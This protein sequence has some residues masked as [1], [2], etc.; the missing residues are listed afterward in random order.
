MEYY[1]QC[2]DNIFCFGIVNIGSVENMSSHA[3]KLHPLLRWFAAL[4][5]I[6]WISAQGLCQTHCLSS[7][8]NDDSGEANCH[9]NNSS[10]SHH[11]DERA[12]KPNNEDRS[13][14]AS[15]MT[16]KAALSSSAT[17]PFIT[18]QFSLLYTLAP[19]TLSL[20]AT[21]IEPVA[22][23]SRQ[24]RLR[25]WVFTPEVCLGPAFRSLAPPISS[26]T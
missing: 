21:A 13:T 25:E 2:I 22:S 5:L 19:I 24:A 16:L 3:T 9:V 12:P 26:L 8:C 10:D 1:R 17:A 4:T 20:D 18:P 6:A 15:C 14:D 11:G 7:A 23:L